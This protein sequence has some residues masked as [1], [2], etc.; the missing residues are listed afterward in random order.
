[1]WGTLEVGP[2]LL[3][4]FNNG[5][6]LFVVDV[7]VELHRDHQ[8]DVEGNGLKLVTARVHLQEYTSNGIVRGIAFKDN[9]EGGVKVV[10]D[11]DG[12]EGF[13]EEGEYAL[14]LA[15]PVLWSVLS[16]ELIERFGDPRV[17]IN[18]PAVEVSKTKKELHLL[19]ILGQ[20]PIEDLHLSRIHANAVLG[21]NDAKVL[22]F[23]GVK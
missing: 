23:G 17:I 14:A 6:E 8:A 21:N 10:E 11:G 16:C 3:E 4:G 13:F 9:K 2:P 20:R 1:M 5:K 15:V 12:G 7:I 22:N 18:E 19:H